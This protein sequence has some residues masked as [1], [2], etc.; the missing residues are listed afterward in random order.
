MKCEFEIK[1]KMFCKHSS[2]QYYFIECIPTFFRFRII[3]MWFVSF[4]VSFYFERP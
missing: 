4:V 1:I 3:N 2:T